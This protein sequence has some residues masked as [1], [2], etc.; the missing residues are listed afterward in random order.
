MVIGCPRARQGPEVHRDVRV[1]DR[2][3]LESEKKLRSRS[4]NTRT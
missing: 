1:A 2:Q 4:L 3:I